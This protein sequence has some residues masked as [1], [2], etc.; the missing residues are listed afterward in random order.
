[1]STPLRGENGI[2]YIYDAVAEAY[3]PV[4]CLTSNSLSTTVEVVE[5]QT[6]CAPGV[7]EKSA[8]VFS[9]SIALEGEYI[10]TES[11]GGDTTKKS[12]DN[13]LVLQEARELID[14][15]I[16][17]DTTDATSVKYYG[18]ALLTDLEA[19]FPTNENSTFSGTLDGS[20]NILRSD[21]YNGGEG[22]GL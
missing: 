13:L 5:R 15:K 16:D 14:W 12:H 18:K 19:T 9:Y 1:M 17:T 3:K 10:D 21:P 20:G 7:I 4:A 2:V 22:E 6:K 11:V 8:G